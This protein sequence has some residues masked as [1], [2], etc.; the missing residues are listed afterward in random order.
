[1][2]TSVTK[3]KED[4]SQKVWN[5]IWNKFSAPLCLQLVCKL[6]NYCKGW[7]AMH[8]AES[9]MLL[10]AGNPS[11]CP[12]PCCRL[13]DKSLRTKVYVPADY[14]HCSIFTVCQWVWGYREWEWAWKRKETLQ[15]AV[16]RHIY[17]YS[18]WIMEMLNKHNHICHLNKDKGHLS[19][20]QVHSSSPL[21]VCCHAGLELCVV[22]ET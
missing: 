15:Q 19:P 14:I 17:V 4:I 8:S 7:W 13:D 20:S 16:C 3:I 18:R 22:G 2:K 1:M 11:V 21:L 10:L 6:W 12:L 5:K 9:P